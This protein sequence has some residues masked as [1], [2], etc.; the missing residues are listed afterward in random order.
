MDGS[1]PDKDDRKRLRATRKRGRL[2]LR[3]SAP[4]VSG[5]QTALAYV[6]QRNREG[7]SDDGAPS[8][9]EHGPAKRARGDDNAANRTP[10]IAEP[11]QGDGTAYLSVRESPDGARGGTHRDHLGDH[12]WTDTVLERAVQQAE[13]SVAGIG[14]GDDRDSSPPGS[15]ILGG[16]GPAKRFKSADASTGRADSPASG[17]LSPIPGPAFGEETLYLSAQG[18]LQ[19]ETRVGARNVRF[20]TP[21]SRHVERRGSPDI[22]DSVAAR[23][24]SPDSSASDKLDSQIF[25]P[26]AGGHNT[27]SLALLPEDMDQYSGGM[28]SGALGGPVGQAA[29]G[30]RFRAAYGA[31]GLAHGGGAGLAEFARRTAGTESGHP[32]E[33]HGHRHNHGQGGER[34]GRQRRG[35]DAGGDGA[36]GGAGR[37]SAG[38]V[39]GP[40]PLLRSAPTSGSF[41]VTYRNKF[42]IKTWAYAGKVITTEGAVMGKFDETKMRNGTDANLPQP[43]RCTSLA[44][45]PVMHLAMYISPVGW[46][47]LPEQARVS[48][49]GVRVIPLGNTVSFDYGSSLTGS[50]TSEHVVLYARAKGLESK[51]PVYPHWYKPDVQ[52]PMKLEGATRIHK[53]SSTQENNTW[54]HVFTSKV[55]QENRTCR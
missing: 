24:A 41:S 34:G 54:D 40:V 20:D 18:G 8:G 4:S 31:G 55:G 1:G 7:E 49:V 38:G 36:S 48:N 53:Y 35:A 9:D 15:P 17:G 12:G 19:D 16:A 51:L 13:Q 50:A 42:I 25:H 27:A 30:Q 3:G 47:L 14:H 11:A 10:D 39:A 22:E 43:T 33:S 23:S 52:D 21:L 32:L 28:G 5:F 26:W 2:S 6:Q 46:E 37:A 44:M 45:L 29:V